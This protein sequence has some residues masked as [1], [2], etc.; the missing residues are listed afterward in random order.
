MTNATAKTLIVRSNYEHLKSPDLQS[1]TWAMSL[2]KKIG[3]CKCATTT[4]KPEIQELN[5]REVK[6]LLQ[7]QV[8]NLVEK[9]AV[10]HSM[11]MNFDQTLRKFSPVN[12]HG[13]L[14]L[15]Q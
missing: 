3:F 12:S 1:A 5:K 9:Y 15:L 2:F 10:T 14:A 4:S 7:Q 13:S 8:A 6:M 11:I